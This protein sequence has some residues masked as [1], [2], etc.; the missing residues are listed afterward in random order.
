VF[1]TMSSTV[2]ESTKWVIEN[3]DFVKINRAK[4]NSFCEQFTIQKQHHWLKDL[5]FDL[6]VLNEQQ[7]VMLVVVFNSISFSYW[8]NPYWLT[9]YKGVNYTRGSTSLIASIFR[10][11]DEGYDFLSANKLAELKMDELTYILRGNTVMPMMEQRLHVLNELGQVLCAMYDSDF[12][13]VIK[14]AK[15][16][17]L[18]LIDIILRDFPCF[19]DKE[20][21]KGKTIYFNKR[22]QALVEGIYS[23]YDGNDYGDL[24]D[25]D[26]ITALADYIIPNLLRSKGILEY[27]SPLSHQIDNESPLEKG[28]PEEVE[29][30]SHTI[31]AIEEMRRTLE[32]KNLHVSATQINEFLWGTGRSVNTPFHLVRTTAY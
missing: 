23:L 21:F 31:W 10:A 5:P 7:R 25:I 15:G 18:E 14:S 13:N 20:E 6:S 8:G 4:L 19:T 28:S 12:L 2:L 32:S 11:L 1:S 30:R 24:E 3:A 17:A 27:S 22:A 29:I 9:E 26:K 16:N